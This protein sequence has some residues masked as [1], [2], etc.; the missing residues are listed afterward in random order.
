MSHINNSLNCRNIGIILKDYS[1][2]TNSLSKK[3][4]VKVGERDMWGLPLGGIAN[5]YYAEHEL[6]QWESNKFKATSTDYMDYIRRVFSPDMPFDIKSNLMNEEL[7]I[8]QGTLSTFEFGDTLSSILNGI[9]SFVTADNNTGYGSAYSKLYSTHHNIYG[10]G[11]GVV[12]NYNMNEPKRNINGTT[13]TLMSNMALVYRGKSF[14]TGMLQWGAGG[15]FADYD[16]I[17]D[18]MYR[19]D[20]TEANYGY[21]LNQQFGNAGMS[22]V[23]LTH[24]DPIKGPMD[25]QDDNKGMFQPER[26]TA[27]K[28]Y[29]EDLGWKSK[30]FYTTSMAFP[31]YGTKAKALDAHIQKGFG[32]G[33]E[34][35]P[36]KVGVYPIIRANH[37][38][39]SD[40]LV[41]NARTIFDI[42]TRRYG[43]SNVRFGKY[44]MNRNI[45]TA[46]SS[47]SQVVN[48]FQYAESEKNEC[49]YDEEGNVSAESEHSTHYD[50]LI[51]HTDEDVNACDANDS[52]DIIGENGQAYG[53]FHPYGNSD[54]LTHKDIISHT[55]QAFINGDYESLVARFHTTGDDGK[56]M[57]ETQTAL[58]VQFGLSHGRN[59]L[60]KCVSE[61]NPTESNSY[62]NPYCRVWTYHHQYHT[63]QNAIRGGGN[64]FNRQASELGELTRRGTADYSFRATASS[65]GE[66]MEGQTSLERFSVLNFDNNIVNI[67]PKMDRNGNADQ[68][69][70]IKRCML[71]IENLAWRDNFKMFGNEGD[72]FNNLSKDSVGPLGGRIMWFPPYGVDFSE[73][74]NAGWK[75][76]GAFI[77]RGEPVKV[78][79]GKTVRSGTL[80]FQMVVDH[81]SIIDYID[82]KNDRIGAVEGSFAGAFR[83]DSVDDT[84]STEQT[85]L[86]FFAGCDVLR[87]QPRPTVKIPVIL[88]DDIE[89]TP[90]TNNDV[91]PTPPED[92]EKKDDG[93]KEE[94]TKDTSHCIMFV[95]YYPNNFSGLDN[96]EEEFMYRTVPDADDYTQIKQ[97]MLYLVNGI[98]TQAYIEGFD[99]DTANTF[100]GLNGAYAESNGG[101]AKHYNDLVPVDY[102]DGL[103]QG[104]YRYI[105]NN[106]RLRALPV[107]I[108]TRWQVVN[109][110]S[111]TSLCVKSYKAYNDQCTGYTTNKDVLSQME[112]T[113]ES[114]SEGRFG[115][116][117][118]PNGDYG[119]SLCQPDWRYFSEQQ[120][121][122]NDRLSSHTTP[123]FMVVKKEGEDT[124]YY[125]P[126]IWGRWQRENSTD[127]EYRNEWMYKTDNLSY[128]K[129]NIR[130]RHQQE[131]MVKQEDD[132][133]TKSYYHNDY[134]DMQSFGL[135]CSMGLG[136]VVEYTLK[137]EQ[138]T[139][140]D[141]NKG[142]YNWEIVDG[143]KVYKNGDTELI[144]F[145]DFM[146]GAYMVESDGQGDNS[147][148][149]LKQ[150]IPFGEETYQYSS[151]H[152]I[153]NL[154][155]N[156]KNVNVSI[157]GA[158]SQQGVSNN[159]SVGDMAFTEEYFADDEKLDANSAL[160]KHRG[161]AIGKYL[162]YIFKKAGRTVGTEDAQNVDVRIS[163]NNIHV[164]NVNC[165][166]YDVN[167]IQAKAGRC[168]I[169]K[170]C[171][172]IAEKEEGTSEVK[173]ETTVASA[174]EAGAETILLQA[175]PTVSE[176]E[177]KQDK[178]R[179]QIIEAMAPMKTRYEDEY[180][181]FQTIDQKAPF[182]RDKIKEKIKYF[183]PAY[184]AISPEGFNARLTFLQ[185]C[186]RQGPTWDSGNSN[187]ASNLAF[188]RPPVCVLRLGDFIYSRVIIESV[189]IQYDENMLW[190]LNPEGIGVQP[191][192]ATV[193]LKLT[194][195]GGQDITGPISRLQNAVSFNYYANTRIYDDRAEQIY[196]DQ[197]KKDPYE[198]DFIPN[199][200]Q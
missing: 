187:N 46:G 164:K 160:A 73:D 184:H 134:C 150:L 116:E 180:S 25:F 176:I 75:D 183:D 108:T 33:E 53:Y 131:V 99:K 146:V 126:T 67:T 83:T 24:I 101:Y 163:T 18:R 197:D 104:T 155:K 194:F 93:E 36:D 140:G 48:R 76:A 192:L 17:S 132:G 11:V 42:Y 79:G 175:K 178:E 139:Q 92:N 80:K 174:S 195:L 135:N 81:P 23:G 60:K 44:Q 143:T 89:N 54:S 1:N 51:D 90:V 186:C 74:V 98:G 68:K 5:P 32:I 172:D 170:I 156:G 124:P 138:F 21:G 49:F 22:Y 30:S 2:I 173:E 61:I 114:L 27:Y 13:D 177:Q 29:Y 193:T 103:M 94:K 71:A 145:A 196:Y 12:R 118:L 69:W 88:E 182:L 66:I 169:V 179:V 165:A 58:S 112:K 38:M 152:I 106:S 9:Q 133:K 144:S 63:L 189:S 129:G 142:D 167:S 97:N 70:D 86:R 127:I 87:P 45:G 31:L 154:I 57:Q 47:S 100:Y 59:L 84:G 181:F 185:Q 8:N 109:P 82:K 136:N 157:S 95:V 26:L 130:K 15:A 96:K 64:A 14:M 199:I 147:Q 128:K 34:Q 107:D 77:G 115:Y 198:F 85:L 119:I 105:E 28:A 171:F 123:I 200:Y 151:S 153:W 62:E 65:A 168:A 3:I 120:D 72:T 148:E 41:P 52:E 43:K 161:K 122:Q 149:S 91:I 56:T 7:G 166:D 55:N 39:E 6:S 35:L 20:F 137:G 10:D 111:D 141:R 102:T 121:G 16:R 110:D 125:M 190:D 158:S 40:T 113:Q 188:G 117:M 159:T 191:M 78:F 19:Y 37:P 50:T 162:E 4:G